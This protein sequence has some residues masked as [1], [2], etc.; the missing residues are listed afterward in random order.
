MDLV[1]GTLPNITLR[2]WRAQ[3]HLSRAEMAD[4][5][6]GSPAGITERLVCD[7]ERIRRW[8]SGEV[9][10]PS[11]P[12]PRALKEVTGLEPARLGF[13]PHG[14]QAS[15]PSARIEVADA[16]RAEAELVDT[17]DLAHGHR[18]GPGP[19]NARHAPGSRRAALPSP[20]ASANELRARTRQR[21]SAAGSRDRP[22]SLKTGIA[23]SCPEA[24]TPCRIGPA[25][26]G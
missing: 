17:L 1:T 25:V 23:R 24:T 15:G 19:R 16:F 4:R 8:E 3:Q 11:P 18:L 6:N 5:I 21:L 9:R 7:E 12:C 22:V 10:C 14:Q 26:E 2:N 20:S 13:L